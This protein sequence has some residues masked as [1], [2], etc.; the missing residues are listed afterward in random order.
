V[1]FAFESATW[2]L[3][4]ARAISYR[5]MVVSIERVRHTV[6]GGRGNRFATQARPAGRVR[7]PGEEHQ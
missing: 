4:V 6:E 5:G 2:T 3:L 7:E 1:Q